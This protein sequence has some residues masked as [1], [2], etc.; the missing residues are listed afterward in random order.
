MKRYLGTLGA[1]LGDG[2]EMR[3]VGERRMEKVVA[4]RS[5]SKRESPGYGEGVW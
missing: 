2:R 5:E 4:G 3:S 1:G